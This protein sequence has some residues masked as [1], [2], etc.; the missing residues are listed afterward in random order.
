MISGVRRGAKVTIWLYPLTSYGPD[1]DAMITVYDW[2]VLEKD[3]RGRDRWRLDP[4]CTRDRTALVKF[5]HIEHY[6]FAVLGVYQ[7]V[8]E[9]E[10]AGDLRFRCRCRRGYSSLG[11]RRAVS[12]SSDFLIQAKTTA[13]F[14]RLLNRRRR[15]RRAWHHLLPAAGTPCHFRVIAS[16]LRTKPV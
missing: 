9:A 16:R 13:T 10:S 2:R 14:G 7:M 3:K 1:T 11:E 6:R 12:R 8:G 5:P 15:W 4:I